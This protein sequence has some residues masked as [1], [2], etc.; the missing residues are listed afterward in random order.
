VLG[1]QLIQLLSY[2]LVELLGASL[3]VP[4]RLRR[5]VGCSTVRDARPGLS[6]MICAQLICRR[7]IGA[8][9]RPGVLSLVGAGLR[10]VIVDARR[11]GF[12]GAVTGDAGA[13]CLACGRGVFGR[14]GGGRLLDRLAGGDLDRSGDRERRLL[15]G[16]SVDSNCGLIA[17]GRRQVCRFVGYFWR[18]ACEVV[19]GRRGRG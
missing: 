16:S 19:G 9:R 7:L 18:D 6:G 15:S 5:V 10:L 1:S 14:L 4:A 3:G 13:V 8:I 12:L 11:P 17:A 2:L